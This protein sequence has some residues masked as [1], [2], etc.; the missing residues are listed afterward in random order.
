M[1]IPFNTLYVLAEEPVNNEP[2]SKDQTNSESIDDVTNLHWVEGSSATVSWTG[3]EEAN[4][5]SVLVT[6]YYLDGTTIIGSVNT[7]TTATELDVQQEI[8]NIIGDAEYESV[9]VMATVYAQ[10]KQDGDVLI[11]SSGVSSNIIEYRLSSLIQIPT[12][13]NLVLGDDHYL[14]FD[15][16]ME[17]P[18]ECIQYAWINVMLSEGPGLGTQVDLKGCFEG[19]KCRINVED[20][21]RECYKSHTEDGA[22]QIQISVQLFGEEGYSNS[23]ES[24]YSNY[25]EY[26]GDLIQIPTPTNL[27]LGDDYYLEFDCDME[28][29]DECIQ[30][31]W[32]NVMLSEGSGLGTQVDLKGCF[33]GTK[34]RID[35]EDKLRECYKSHTEDGAAQIQISVQLFGEEGYFNSIESEY[36]NYIEYE[37]KKAVE[38]VS[39]APDAPIICQSHSY[40][41]GK[42]IIPED[43]Y[44]ESIDWSSDDESIFMVDEDGQ[45]TGVTPGTA[46]VTATIGDVTATVPVTVYAISSNIEDPN[47]NE[48][49]TNAAG[50][51]IDDIA[52]NE[53]PNLDDTDIEP[54]DIEEIKEEI[55]EAIEN[56]DTFHTDVVA[57]QQYYEKYKLNWGQIQKATRYLNAQFEGA[58]NIEVEMYHKDHDNNNHHIGNITEL[59]NEIS[60]TFDLPTGMKEQQSGNTKK[61]VL[62]RVHKNSDG[63]MEYSPVN[64]E[65]NDDGTFTAQ[66]DQYSDFIWCSVSN[67]NDIELTLAQT[68]NGIQL[69]WN[70]LEGA[71]WYRVYRKTEGGAWGKIA[72]TRKQEYLDKKV[73]NQTEYI[74]RIVGYNA[75]NEALNKRKECGRLLYIDNVPNTTIELNKSGVKLTW[76][77]VEGTEW[78]RVYR[79]TEGGDWSKIATTRKQEFIDKTVENQ[80]EYIYGVVC[81]NASNEALCKR[82]ECGRILYTDNVPNTTIELNKSGVKL[83][84]NAVEG[85]EWYRVYRKTEGGDWSKIATTRKQEFIDKTVENQTEYIYGVVCYNASNEALCK[86]KECGRILFSNE[87]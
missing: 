71:E 17:N 76:N 44:Y 25:I 69:T 28:N 73:E 26:Q 11:Q 13:A 50:E 56:G 78:Y 51:I 41:L 34:C 48:E 2:D 24:E 6:V 65:I 82:K 64:Y 36:S 54:E 68:K 14:E 8:H 37:G 46:N 63:T 38:V 62:V 5:Y 58:Y 10:K 43:A 86:R 22:A 66:S 20:K 42:T 57:I 83:T 4:Y 35:V 33:E 53:N 85:T 59:D 29:P 31:A 79:K 84:W 12:P 7:G 87:N 70:E 74:Y 9:G 75:S 55:Y 77:A 81:Y 47:D 72:T 45:I 16:D 67:E 18:D 3:V 19:T 21:L 60:F 40:Y 80:T 30:Y 1:L 49:V 15:C 39:I 23:K 27:V 52:N 61:Y 32:I